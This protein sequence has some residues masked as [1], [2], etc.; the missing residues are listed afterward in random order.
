MNVNEQK[1]LTYI[2]NLKEEYSILN[3]SMEKWHKA[4]I[5]HNYSIFQ[6]IL[7]VSFCMLSM[8]VLF[9]LR[10]KTDQHKFQRNTSLSQTIY[11]QL[12]MY[13]MPC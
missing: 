3:F 7:Q 5:F 2:I 13:T 6:A 1:L 12:S 8:S 10:P 4:L 11:K 9:E